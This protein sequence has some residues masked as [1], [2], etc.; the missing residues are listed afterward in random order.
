MTTSHLYS[1][2]LPIRLLLGNMVCIHLYAEKK[3]KSPPPARQT[4]SS[5]A[6]RSRKFSAPR[7]LTT[8]ACASSQSGSA[9]ARVCLPFSVMASTR[10]RRSTPSLSPAPANGLYVSQG[11]PR[12]KTSHELLDSSLLISCLPEVNTVSSHAIEDVCG[13]YMHFC[14][15]C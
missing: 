11:A 9:F 8:E 2:S 10:F 3:S 5:F 4:V 1:I 7:A 14:S 12:Y 6:R 15:C 13:A